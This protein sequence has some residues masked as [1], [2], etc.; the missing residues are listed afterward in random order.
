MVLISNKAYHT[1]V[2]QRFFLNIVQ[3]KI[4]I[5][6]YNYVLVMGAKVYNHK[7]TKATQ[8]TEYTLIL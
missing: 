1:F 3:Q 4:T 7:I 6:R 2:A 5:S 8:L